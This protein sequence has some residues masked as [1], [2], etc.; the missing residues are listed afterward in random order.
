MVRIAT[1][2]AFLLIIN[3]YFK[4]SRNPIHTQI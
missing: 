3:L 1:F 2:H 4:V